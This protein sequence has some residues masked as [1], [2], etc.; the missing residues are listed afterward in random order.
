MGRLLI[1]FISIL[2]SLSLLAKKE[3]SCAGGAFP[4]IMALEE[5]VSTATQRMIAS[6]DNEFN[7]K[8]F[9]AHIKKYGGDSGERNSDEMI[10]ARLNALFALDK[11]TGTSKVDTHHMFYRA[12]PNVFYSV[13]WEEMNR[14]DLEENAIR[15]L[16]KGFGLDHTALV[17][18]DVHTENFSTFISEDKTSDQG[19]ITRNPKVSMKIND[20]DEAGDG[21]VIGGFLR[22]LLSGSM[23][24]DFRHENLRKSNGRR[25]KRVLSK[26]GEEDGFVSKLFDGYISGLTSKPNESVVV[27]DHITDESLKSYRKYSDNYFLISDKEKEGYSAAVQAKQVEIL[28]QENPGGD[29]FGNQDVLTEKSGDLSSENKNLK[30]EYSIP[31]ES[32][33]KLVAEEEVLKSYESD[34]I[35]HKGK[36]KEK[37]EDSYGKFGKKIEDAMV[38][39]AN[40]DFTYRC[41]DLY[42]PQG[43]SSIPSEEDGGQGELFKA[44]HHQAFVGP[45]IKKSLLHSEQ[46][47]YLVKCKWL[48]GSGGLTSYTFYEKSR[49]GEPPRTIKVKPMN[50]VSAT[51]YFGDGTQAAPTDAERLAKYTE[52]L[53]TF[54]NEEKEAGL[55]ETNNF[56]Q[57]GNFVIIKEQKGWE[58]YS[59]FA[60]R[61]NGDERKK[62][63]QG[64]LKEVEGAIDFLL[65]NDEA[66]YTS[67]L[68]NKLNDLKNFALNPKNSLEDSNYEKLIASLQEIIVRA[69]KKVKS[70]NEGLEE[71]D[72]IESFENLESLPKL[73]LVPRE[74][75]DDA[76]RML[77]NQFKVLGK[78]HGNSLRRDDTQYSDFVSKITDK[79]KSEKIQSSLIRAKDRLKKIFNGYYNACHG[80]Y[81]QRLNQD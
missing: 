26:N 40:S 41:A 2:F 60:V 72:K 71:N 31:V 39:Y 21:P 12:W 22:L 47:P 62:V 76:Q 81:L 17:P 65:K 1:L 43:F 57:F 48:G 11:E 9:K 53:D 56:G 7:C 73:S 6:T 61:L 59:P 42:F 54:V 74:G 67:D 80:E 30:D 35:K 69:N 20:F 10:Q 46:S 34:L 45:Y 51:Q 19:S 27:D 28:S 23:A 29:D 77:Q 68:N 5:V 44:H 25:R 24:D 70:F 36:V 75:R 37:K 55:I 4:E 33:S 18:G 66:Q 15:E 64:N 78:A 52:S 3:Q 50:K 49:N 8:N 16:F 63:I 38:T 58:S 14:T 32:R 13:L 79:D